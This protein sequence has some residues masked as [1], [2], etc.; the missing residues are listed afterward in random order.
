MHHLEKKLQLVLDRRKLSSLTAIVP[1]LS[2]VL[3]RLMPSSDKAQYDKSRLSQILSRAIGDVEQRQLLESV[4]D[5]ALSL[6]TDEVDDTHWRTVSCPVEVPTCHVSWTACVR[7]LLMLVIDPLRSSSDASRNSNVPAGRH[8]RDRV[9][10]QHFFQV[11]TRQCR[12]IES[13]RATNDVCSCFGS[14]RLDDGWAAKGR[15]SRAGTLSVP[16][17]RSF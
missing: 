16:T 14:S 4:I 11:G 15:I 12:A 7:M 13:K 6:K 17:A 1:A 10:A 9:I 5:E 3:L 2:A 8:Y